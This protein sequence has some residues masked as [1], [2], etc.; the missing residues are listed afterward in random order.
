MIFTEANKNNRETFIQTSNR[1]MMNETQILGTYHHKEGP[2]LSADTSTEKRISRLNCN[3]NNNI[4]LQNQQISLKN[5]S[6]ETFKN[7]LNK[8]NSACPHSN[9][10]HYAKVYLINPE[11]V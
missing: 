1:L 9:K 3:S 2:P 8:I 6:K 7:K 5:N 10:I 4:Y 11:H